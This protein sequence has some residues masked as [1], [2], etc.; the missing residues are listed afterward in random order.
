MTVYKYTEP[1][2]AAGGSRRKP[3]ATGLAIWNS[4]RGSELDGDNF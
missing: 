1:V 2:L 4:E 3:H